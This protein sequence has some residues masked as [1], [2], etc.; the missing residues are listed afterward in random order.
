MQRNRKKEQMATFHPDI[1][2]F[3]DTFVALQAQRHEAD[4][5]P[6]PREAFTRSQTLRDIERARQAIAN[7]QAIPSPERRRFAV[8][9]LIGQRG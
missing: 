3:S 9:L 5:N 7:F 4:Y 1:Q 2:D 6:N 8:H